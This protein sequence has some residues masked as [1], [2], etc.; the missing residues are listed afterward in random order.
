MI[1]RRIAH[2][3]SISALGSATRADI[4]AGRAVDKALQRKLDTEQALKQYSRDPA[5]TL[6]DKI[7]SISDLLK[8]GG[9]P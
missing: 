7:N 4:A 6:L 8:R 9:N 5:S 2:A 3:R 1:D